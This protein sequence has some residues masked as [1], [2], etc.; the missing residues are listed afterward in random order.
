[1]QRMYKSFTQNLQ[2]FEGCE[3]RNF[4]GSN[5]EKDLSVTGRNYKKSDHQDKD[6]S[7]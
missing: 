3:A 1:M 4:V 6:V 2:I 5:E 7:Q